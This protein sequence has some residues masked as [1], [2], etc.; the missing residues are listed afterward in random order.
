MRR[1]VSPSVTAFAIV[2][3]TVI[4]NTPALAQGCPAPRF[5]AAQAFEVGRYPQS[6]A[7]GDFNRDGRI[8]LAIANNG[9]NSIT[10]LSGK[11]DGTFQTA[12]NFSLG[13]APSSVA[14]GDFNRDGNSDL[15]VAGSTNLSVFLGNGG[16][17]FGA[18]L[19]YSVG[20]D[21]Q[22]VAVSDLNGDGKPDLVLANSGSTNVSVLLNSG[23]GSFQAA[24]SY[25][26]QVGFIM[27]DVPR[28]VAAG[29]FNGDGKPDLAGAVGGSL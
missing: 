18:P 27:G 25:S 19:N 15:A 16:G 1:F 5:L 23:D 21:A 11:G 4:V 8:D 2:F 3:N 22:S 26:V 29:D 10:I 28:F 17:S 7:T 14:A 24:V 12:V 6:L 9:S 20:P 13:F